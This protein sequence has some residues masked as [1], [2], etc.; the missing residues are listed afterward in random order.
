MGEV[1]VKQPG[2]NE[3]VEAVLLFHSSGPWTDYRRRRWRELTG[4]DDPTAKAL[5]D[6]LRNI[7]QVGRSIM[8]TAP[9]SDCGTVVMGELMTEL[10]KPDGFHRAR[11]LIC[12]QCM[13]LTRWQNWRE[14]NWPNWPMPRGEV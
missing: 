7:R 10:I 6:W 14:K 5:C 11:V 8:D 4:N 13:K 9:C 3:V 1:P 12:D 2:V